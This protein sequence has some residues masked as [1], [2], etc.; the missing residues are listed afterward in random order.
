MGRPRLSG[1]LVF[2]PDL[3]VALGFYRGVLGLEVR[4]ESNDHVEM[5]GDGFD[6]TLFRCEE[7]G[8]ADGYS[9]R[10]GSS[11]AFAVDDVDAEARRL[12]GLG[13]SVLHDPPARGPI[14]RYVA[15]VDPF[16]TVH[17]LVEATS[18]D[19]SVSGRRRA[20]RES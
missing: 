5:R 12:R 1:V 6:L 20:A 17:E 3:E 4:R 19:G 2:V 8:A 14:G 15:F 11:I 13:V 10:A 7:G 9:S 18:T 16:G